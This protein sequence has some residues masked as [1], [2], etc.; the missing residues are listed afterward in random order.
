MGWWNA[1]LTVWGHKIDPLGGAIVTPV[2]RIQCMGGAPSLQGF[3]CVARVPSAS[4]NQGRSSMSDFGFVCS[5]YAS[6]NRPLIIVTFVDNQGRTLWRVSRLSLKP[7]QLEMAHGMQ[8][9]ISHILFVVL[10]SCAG[11]CLGC[12]EDVFDC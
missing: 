2:S 9:F 5:R 3:V 1:L 12:H 4:C 7:S 10:W 11:M 6:P 8:I